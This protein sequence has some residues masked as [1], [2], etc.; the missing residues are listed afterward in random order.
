MVEDWAGGVVLEIILH[1]ASPGRW[2]FSSL[3]QASILYPANAA[4]YSQLY[5]LVVIWTQMHYCTL[6]YMTLSPA[7]SA[8]CIML[9]K[10]EKKV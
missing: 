3:L 5:L 1:S 2:S 6:L 8:R 7:V 10:V 4:L 9:S